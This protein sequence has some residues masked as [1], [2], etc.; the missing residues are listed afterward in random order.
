M[1]FFNRKKNQKRLYIVHGWG[2][3]PNSNWFPW[4]K[5]Q[6]ET[7]GFTAEI[8]EM[9]D[10]S[11]PNMGSWLLRL[12]DIAKNPDEDTFFVGHSL[13]AMAILRY[14]EAIPEKN[15]AGGAILVAGCCEPINVPEIK[16]FFTTPLD[17]QKIKSTANKFVAINSDNDPWIPLH[18]G[19]NLKDKFD[20]ELIILP[21]AGH[22][23]DTFGFN[24]LPIA[25]EKLKELASG[26]N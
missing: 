21:K 7:I 16:S 11:N 1:W 12:Y 3:Q 13:G 22:I 5:K 2:G 24:E 10:S 20:A 8:P 23:N 6:A 15:R 18:F 26:S 19:E 9:P 4:L 17:Y 14:L 25:Y